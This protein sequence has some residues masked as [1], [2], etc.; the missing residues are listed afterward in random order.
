[1]DTAN[2]VAAFYVTDAGSLLARRIKRL[3]P[4]LTIMKFGKGV[5]RNVWNQQ[6]LLIFI[7]ATGIVVR[8]ISP[9]LKDKKS[10][11]AVIVLDEKGRYAISLASGHLGG[12]NEKAEEIARFLGGEAIITTASDVNKVPAIDLFARDNALLIDDWKLLPRIGTRFI[13][14]GRLNVYADIELRL[15]A[16]FVKVSDPASADLLITN[17]RSF[18][19]RRGLYLRPKNIVVGIGCNRGTSAK[20]IE[21]AVRK[22]FD[23]HNLSLIRSRFSDDRQEKGR[24]RNQNVCREKFFKRALLLPRRAEWSS[25]HIQIRGCFPRDRCKGSG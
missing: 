23:E 15:P 22:A 13:N 21:N 11:P 8:T 5:V 6:R 17:R 20:E 14:E 25:R 3:Y 1:M 19:A 2:R 16:G 10:D 9:L 24:T 7:M 18:A 12:A 4:D